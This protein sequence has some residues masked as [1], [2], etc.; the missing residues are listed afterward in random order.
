MLTKS[1]ISRQ[2]LN[3]KFRQALYDA[4]L[5]NQEYLNHC[6]ISVTELIELELDGSNWTNPIIKAD[7]IPSS[8][9][10]QIVADLKKQFN[11]NFLK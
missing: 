3:V 11:I 5:V 8:C 10:I 7:N 2:E 9:Y 6:S 4:D 1:F